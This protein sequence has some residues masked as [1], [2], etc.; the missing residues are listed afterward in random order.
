MK[1]VEDVTVIYK[2]HAKMF[3]NVIFVPFFNPYE[4]QHT[5][6]NQIRRH[7]ATVRVWRLI[8]FCTFYREVTEC[9]LK[10]W[11]NMWII[12]IQQPFDSKGLGREIHVTC[13]IASFTLLIHQ[14]L[15]TYCILYLY[16]DCLH[17]LFYRGPLGRLANLAERATL[18]KYCINKI[19]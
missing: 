17:V 15:C 4:P 16:G 6:Q 10:I 19:K 14:C 8:R 1:V 12:D 11:F 18:L 7:R 2:M 9:T 5:L 3:Q 13:F